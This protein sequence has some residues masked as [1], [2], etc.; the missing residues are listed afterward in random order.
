MKL[1]KLIGKTALLGIL[2][3][4]KELVTFIFNLPL[5]LV[6]LFESICQGRLLRILLWLSY[7]M[8]QNN[9][10][11]WHKKP[12]SEMELLTDGIHILLLVLAVWPA[13]KPATVKVTFAE[14]EE[15]P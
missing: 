1:L 4:G 2:V 3:L 5:F 7:F 10:Y 11:G 14:K 13:N 12:E 9:Y 8:A 6:D 15:K